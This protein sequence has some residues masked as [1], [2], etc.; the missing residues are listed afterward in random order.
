MLKKI[1]KN[2]LDYTKSMSD[3]N[4]KVDCLVYANNYYFA[5]RYLKSM[6][7]NV[8]E[9]PFIKAFGISANI[10]SI[11]RIANLTQVKYISSVAKVFAQ[12]NIAKKAMNYENIDKEIFN[13]SGVN[14]AIIDTG[15]AEHVD[16]CSFDN[17][18]LHFEDFVNGKQVPYDDN[19]HGT[20]VASVLAG[21][22]FLS[23]KRFSGIA[24][25]ANI[26]MCKAL[27]EK[28]ETGSLTI[29]KAMQWIYDNRERFNIRVVCMSLGS[30]PLDSGDP[31][32]QGAEAL[33]NSGIV[34]VAAAGNSGPERRTIKSPG[35]SGRI[36]TVGALDDGRNINDVS[37]NQF[38]IAN[39]S[40]R[41]PS[42]N[43][44]KPDC[45]ASGVDIVCASPMGEFYTKM[46]GTSVST[47]IIAGACAI[48]LQKYPNLNPLQVKSRII[49]SCDR[50]SGDRNTEGF[51]V[52]NFEKLIK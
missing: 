2:L 36:I 50:L 27:D 44:Y 30:Q 52:L 34:V 45:L 21:N 38:S 42:N 39:F 7:E 3:V 12:M 24:P 14:V 19:G 40:S 23:G 1:D 17:R 35:A 41:G 48:L 20:F 46:S 29:L 13:G 32:M 16:F 10:D 33:W 8:D 47:P 4:Q 25:K 37:K 49:N 31:L 51:G 28:G 22:G 6:Y 9:Y 43:F 26:I 5:K 11:T 15:I 18:I